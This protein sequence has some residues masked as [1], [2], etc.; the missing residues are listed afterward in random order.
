M[1]GTVGLSPARLGVRVLPPG[2]A[3]AFNR[4]CKRTRDRS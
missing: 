3:G 4:R 2:Y 1:I